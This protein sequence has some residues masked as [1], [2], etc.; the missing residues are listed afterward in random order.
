MVDALRGC[1]NQIVHKELCFWIANVL[2]FSHDS[3]I[4]IFT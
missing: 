3:I 2:E 1:F 4:A